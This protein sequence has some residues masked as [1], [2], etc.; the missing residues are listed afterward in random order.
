[1]LALLLVVALLVAPGKEVL[2][3]AQ[4]QLLQQGLLGQ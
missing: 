4:V 1:V 2:L 3:L